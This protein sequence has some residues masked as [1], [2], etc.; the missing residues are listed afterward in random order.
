MLR[1][2]IA[3]TLT[4]G[5]LAGIMLLVALS[6]MTTAGVLAGLSVIVGIVCVAGHAYRRGR[7]D[8]RKAL[9]RALARKEESD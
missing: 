5:N 4:L 8:Y 7:I 3:A 1:D 2:L 9:Q 6:G